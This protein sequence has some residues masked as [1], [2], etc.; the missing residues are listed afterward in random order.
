[1]RIESLTF[2]RFVAALVVVIFH[3]GR[4][5]TGWTGFPVAGPQMVTF[6]F[7]LSGFVMAIA[8]GA[9]ERVA[10]GPFLWARTARIFPVYLAALALVVLSQ[11]VRSKPVGAVELGLSVTL[12]QSWIPP[13]PTVLNS[14]GWSLSVEMFFYATLPGLILFFRPLRSRPGVLLGGVTLFWFVTQCVLTF[15]LKR[16]QQGGSEAL[17]DLVFYFPPSHLCS[18]AMGLAGG[19]VFMDRGWAR[20]SG[21]SALIV[22]LVSGAL[23]VYALDHQAQIEDLVGVPLAFASSFYAPLFL[24]LI[25][26]VGS[27]RWMWSD[28]LAARPLVLLGEASYSLYILQVPIYQLFMRF[29]AP[30]LMWDTLETFWAYTVCLIA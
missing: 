13:F 5:A 22:S 12:L 25:L 11:L 16:E 1:M 27:S 18:F 30:Q 4:Q 21:L 23:V 26:A 20:S 8:Y 24:V 9:K 17:H 15:L 19:L 29:V 7:V 10:V 2:L 14:P 6:F 28:W 3:F